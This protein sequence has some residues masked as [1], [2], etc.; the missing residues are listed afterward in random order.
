MTFDKSVLQIFANYCV[1]AAESM[2]YT[3]VRTAHSAFVKETEDFS[4]TLMN[5]RGLTFASPKT[6][7]ATWY[8]G[9][10]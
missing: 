7:G 3:L 4:C 8:P 6:L 10:T 2:A 1:A 9:S 5:T